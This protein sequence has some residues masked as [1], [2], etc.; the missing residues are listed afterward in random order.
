M[1]PQQAA[2]IPGIPS[3]FI[4]DFGDVDEFEREFW[5]LFRH[6]V[7]AASAVLT[8]VVRDAFAR[9]KEGFG[10]R[11]QVRL[12]SGEHIESPIVI[13]WLRPPGDSVAGICINGYGYGTPPGDSRARTGHIVLQARM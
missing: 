3:H 10:Y 2:T 9:A 6:V 13:G 5:L 8:P 12:L 1:P 11:G 7:R 4:P